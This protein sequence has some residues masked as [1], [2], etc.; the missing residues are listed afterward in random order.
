MF[1][2]NISLQKAFN[3]Q[4]WFFF[5]CFFGLDSTAFIKSQSYDVLLRNGLSGISC[6]ESVT[7]FI[8]A[9]ILKQ[10]VLNLCQLEHVCV[11]TFSQQALVLNACVMPV[12]GT[13]SG[14]QSLSL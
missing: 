9:N 11:V 6:C 5:S 13:N 12:K 8:L 3:L 2:C 10:A 14:F 4:V 7:G 1:M